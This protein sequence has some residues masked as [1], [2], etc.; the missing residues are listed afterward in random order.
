MTCRQRLDKRTLFL[1]QYI[2]SKLQVICSETTPLNG[3]SPP[4]IGVV[5]GIS[6]N[7]T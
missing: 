1:K 6:L 2:A 7:P 5:V 4:L 3:L